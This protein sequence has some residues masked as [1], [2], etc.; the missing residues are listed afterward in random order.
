MKECFEG[1]VVAEGY[2]STE[3]GLITA[4]D[5]IPLNVQYKLVDVPE[6]GYFTS[7]NPPQ[8]EILVRVVGWMG[9]Y[10]EGQVPCSSFV[11]VCLAGG[12]GVMWV[13]MQHSLCVGC[14]RASTRV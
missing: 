10:I 6:L 1:V 7:H 8:G 4:N 11:V 14:G 5:A 12:V 9:V 3:C 2:G 13:C